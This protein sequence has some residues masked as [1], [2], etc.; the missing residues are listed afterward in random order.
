MGSKG[1]SSRLSHGEQLLRELEAAGCLHAVQ[2][3]ETRHEGGL[4]VFATRHIAAGEPILQCPV[5]VLLRP[6]AEHALEEAIAAFSAR[7]GIRVDERMQVQ[8]MLLFERHRARLGATAGV[9]SSYI[10]SLPGSDLVDSLPL[11]WHHKDLHRRARGTALLSDVTTM[12]EHLHALSLAIKSH[13][14]LFGDMLGEVNVNDL[15]WAQAIFWSRAIVLD[16]PKRTECLVPLLDMCNH[17]AG[18]ASELRVVGSIFELRAGRSLRSGDEVCIN[19]GAKG[20]AELLRCHGFVVPDNPAEVCPLM[21][22]RLAPSGLTQADRDDRLRRVGK[23]RLRDRIFLF[24]GGLPETLLPV[25]RVMCVSEEEDLIAAEDA[26]C[27]RAAAGAAAAAS[28]DK[29][30]STEFVT[31]DWSSVDWTKDD[32]FGG[33][34]AVEEEAPIS[35]SGERR[36]LEALLVL[37]REGE[38][39]MGRLSAVEEQQLTE[40]RLNFSAGLE[41]RGGDR[42]ADLA[43]LVYRDGQRSL[44]REARERIQSRLDWLLGLANMPLGQDDDASVRHDE[45]EG[46]RK[47]QYD[48]VTTNA[49]A[50]GVD[51]GHDANSSKATA[52]P[53]CT[54]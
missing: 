42:E 19:Y 33:C 22:S 12:R 26:L 49:D 5:C 14:D 37:L 46:S 10:N 7:S 52:A 15:M 24:R 29:S 25:A 54:L 39:A 51:V 45:G 13:G 31:F 3:G 18:S 8:L 17:R 30:L 20:N 27:G 50:K 38:N 34:D 43:A 44:L 1:L 2:L 4:G 47:R 21:L 32:P 41:S 28:T 9:M 40:V 16:L 23:G 36:T 48:S 6:P 35:S 53:L 11:S